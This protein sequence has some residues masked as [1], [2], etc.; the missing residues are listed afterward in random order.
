MFNRKYFY[1]LI[2]IIAGI[3]LVNGISYFR[4]VPKDE[5]MADVRDSVIQEMIPVITEVDSNGKTVAVKGLDTVPAE[6]V[7]EVIQELDRC[8]QESKYKKQSCEELYLMKA[9]AY[10]KC[11]VRNDCKDLDQ[12]DSGDCILIRCQTG[13]LRKK[14]DDLD[15]KY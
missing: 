14:F 8:L 2:I 4:G 12:I 10:E 15:A 7:K 1:V 5:A 9:A 3:L 11:F 13:A 6:V